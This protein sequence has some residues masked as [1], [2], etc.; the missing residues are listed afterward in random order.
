MDEAI[1]SQAVSNK[2]KVVALFTEALDFDANGT[3]EV[4]IE[5]PDYQGA[6][7]VTALAWSATAMGTATSSIIVK[8][9]ISIEYYMSSF[10][11]VGDSVQNLVNIHFDESLE[12][13]EYEITL[14]T[15]GGILLSQ[16]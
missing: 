15:Q 1:Q 11:S 16:R 14:H 7:S 13:S 5:I 12:A 4:E 6:L 8:D 10:I 9:K 3:A 2:R